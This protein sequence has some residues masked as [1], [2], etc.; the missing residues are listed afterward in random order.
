MHEA[1]P[2]L[3]LQGD[4]HHAGQP[5]FDGIRL[6]IEAGKWTC[7]VGPSG[8]GKSTL[9][10]LIADLDTG[11]E[12]SGT[13][14]AGD[15]RPVTA[16]VAYMAQTDLLAPW[17]DVYENVVLG[18][19]LRGETPDRA[20]AER[21]I[22]RV[23]LEPHRH[24]RPASL[25]GGMRQRAALARMLMED[26]PLALLDEPFAALDA[27]TR[28]EMQELAHEMLG[29]RTVV[30]VTHDPAEAVRLA[31]EIIIVSAAGLS[32]YENLEGQPIRAAEAAETLAMQSDLLRRLRELPQ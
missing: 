22:A 30:L 28:S 31:D 12:F 2:G 15:E 4:F 18:A 29:G 9:L 23:G 19:R 25:S 26:R 6:G 20:R 32:R 3:L 16:R 11:G 7:L 5:L 27:R 13:I 8:V 10:R 24:K 1:P 14:V 21:L 17:L